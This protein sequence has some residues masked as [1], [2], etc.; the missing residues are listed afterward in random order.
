MVDNDWLVVWNMF[1]FYDRPFSWEW[2]VIIPTD[3]L[4][5]FSEG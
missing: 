2:N 1:Y 3:E 4:S 5:Y